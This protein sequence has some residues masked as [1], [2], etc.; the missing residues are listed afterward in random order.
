MLAFVFSNGSKLCTC[1]MKCQLA[2]LKQA[3]AGVI[4]QNVRP[5]S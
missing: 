3:V 2:F 1:V 5:R 4:L